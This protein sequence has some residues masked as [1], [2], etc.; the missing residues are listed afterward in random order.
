MRLQYLLCTLL[1]SLSTSA[2][3]AGNGVAV[4]SVTFSGN[5][6][7]QSSDITDY[8]ALRPGA[9]WTPDLKLLSAQIISSLYRGR[10]FMEASVNVSELAR[11]ASVF[12][13]VEIREGPRYTFGET[14]VSGLA[15]L[16]PQT[17]K[18]ELPYSAGEP[19]SQQKLLSAQGQL[20]ATNWFETLGT[21]VSSAAAGVM[22]VEIQAA[23]K[24]LKWVKGGVGYGSE[25]KERLS[26]GVTH[27]NF[28]DRGYRMDLGGTVSRISLEY[29]ADFTNRHFLDS[30]TELRGSSAWRREL[31][32][33][34]DL[35]SVK[36]ILSL[37]RK[38]FENVYG[39]VRYRLQRTLIYDVDPSISAETPSLSRI[40]SAS[41]ALNRDT[42]DNF[43]YPARGLRSELT[44]ERSGGLWGGDIDF[45]RA[46]LRNTAYRKL[47]DDVTGLVSA[48]CAFVQETGRT[49]DIPIY[50]RLFYGGANS[51]RGYAER[52]VGPA[53]ADGNPLGGKVLLG[54]SAEL[55][56]P[57]Y[58]KLRGAFFTDG[59]QV[60]D[61]LRG[62]AP[63]RWK[64]GAGAGIRYRTPVGPIRADFGYK[65]NPDRPVSP[66]LWR[67][68]L[69]IGEAF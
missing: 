31:R 67:L 24:P 43:F 38:L 25:E 2:S 55:R 65:L 22:D 62:A 69:S 28:L 66:E 20:Y 39:S 42:T 40:R 46:S 8:A 12:L 34:Y 29:R 18:K 48:R 51:V 57:I 5:L 61:S 27:N 21:K 56:F 26:L 49:R 19:F 11:G 32:S 14:S 13:Q 53:D 64:Y 37:G 50:E 17:V 52:G 15:K 30:S 9:A 23:E 44:L 16:R 45:Y 47:F 4:A 1:L 60:A 6:S 35:E 58:K 3:A 7:I 54:A 10:G 63:R 36:N 59:G 68:H 33:G 41:V